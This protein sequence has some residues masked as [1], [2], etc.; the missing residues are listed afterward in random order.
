MLPLRFIS[1][2]KNNN[3][4]FVV[5]GSYVVVLLLVFGTFAFSFLQF[6]E[7]NQQ[8]VQLV[9]HTDLKL[10]L[11]YG[12]RDQIR[13]RVHS[14][15][16]MKNQKDVFLLDEE[17]M[18][19]YSYAG[20]YERQRQQLV[21]LSTKPEE[22]EAILRL[23]LATQTVR[24]PNARALQ[25]LVD[26]HP[27]LPQL[28]DESIAGHNSLLAV[29]Q[30]FVNFEHRSA[31]S[32]VQK[33]QKNF[34][35]MSLVLAL[36]ATAVLLLSF[37]I[38]LGVARFMRHKNQALSYQALHDPLTGLVNRAGFQQKLQRVMLDCQAFH[39]Q[40]VL[41]FM[42]LDRFK[43][44]NDSCG[45]QAGDQLLRNLAELMKQQIRG[46][47]VLARL[48]GDEFGLIL[49]SC[50]LEQGV[51]LAHKIRE[52]VEEYRLHW[53]D[54]DFG[55]GVSIGLVAIDEQEQDA[56]ALLGQ[57][58]AACYVA[59][60][61]GQ[62][63][64]HVVNTHDPS[65]LQVRGEMNWVHRIEMAISRSAFSFDAQPIVL[66]DAESH[67]APR[68]YELLLR[69]EENGQRFSPAEFI[70]AAER[71]QMMNRVDR[72]VLKNALRC[73][74]KH[75]DKSF[76]INLSAQSLSDPQFHRMA[77]TSIERARVNPARLTFEIT[78]TAMVCNINRAV[79]FLNR[80]R[81]MK[82]TIAIDDFGSGVASFAYLQQFPLDYIKID[83]SLIKQLQT[84]RVL[85]VTI[86]SIVEIAALL[87]A[88]T[89]AEYVEDTQ[90][91]ELLSR[92]GVDY[93]QGYL[94]GKPEASEKL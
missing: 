72:W 13:L 65:L 44:V 33:S 78:E 41:L 77:L 15:E 14:L 79:E 25:A 92:L 54:R 30:Q 80:L 17:R 89:I 24:G 9:N 91:R 67:E 82:V 59:K 36:S 93:L 11:A 6:R 12:M 21:D 31:H 32:Q 73:A 75:P 8:L 64:V 56:E 46:Q 74:E 20:T 51:R 19:F 63:G 29:L 55:V 49:Q 10:R 37:L 88:K 18:R 68:H 5:L 27:D 48:G 38:G 58:D 28:I 86:R 90:E 70:P 40:A 22:R 2:F 7:A 34:R 42:D 1:A 16:L 60:S 66:A 53:R 47:D 3:E 50:S 57:V 81:A 62:K 71:F 26:A 85:Q 43:A 39:Q 61:H 35:K 4:I 23:D 76:S 69:L 52:Q 84:N 94:F 45:H 83:G 87:S